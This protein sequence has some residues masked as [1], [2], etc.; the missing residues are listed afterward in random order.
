[1]GDRRVEKT[2]DLGYQDGYLHK[3]QK[4]CGIFA[5]SVHGIGQREIQQDAYGV[6]DE[7]LVEEK[8]ILFVVADGMGGM[9]NGE[10]ASQEAVIACLR[11]HEENEIYDDVFEYMESM[12]VYANNHVNDCLAHESSNYGSTLVAVLIWKGKLYYASVGDS[13]ILLSDGRRMTR[14]NQEHNYWN[15][16]LERVNRGEITMEQANLEPNKEALTSYIGEKCV[17]KIDTNQEGIYL[18]AG[19]RV[20]LCSDGVYRTL[21]LEEIETFLPNDLAKMAMLMDSAIFLKQKSGQDNY[22]ALLIQVQ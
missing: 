16:L 10:R 19:Q 1:M 22:T 21:S 4:D 14:L 12:V 3:F 11:F 9:E 2:V 8:G 6:S 13:W 7:K 18:D 20:I 17:T 15:L 5:A